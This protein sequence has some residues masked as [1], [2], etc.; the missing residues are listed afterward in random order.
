MTKMFDDIIS[1]IE[2]NKVVALILLDL[3]FAFN[4]I[5]H[6]MVLKELQ[7]D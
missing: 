4:T 5:D 3:S 6:A 2:E 7:T 1:E